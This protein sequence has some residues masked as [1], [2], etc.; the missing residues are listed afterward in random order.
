MPPII[1]M[2]FSM[3]CRLYADAIASRYALLFSIFSPI[4]LRH[5]D[6]YAAADAAMPLITLRHAA[7]P[8]FTHD[9]AMLLPFLTLLLR[10]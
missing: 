7:V 3:P 4:R 5:F 10:R 6:S 8:L 1:F 9:A 2:P